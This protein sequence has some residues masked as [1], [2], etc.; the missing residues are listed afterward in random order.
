VSG[1]TGQTSAAVWTE[2][3]IGY[4]LVKGCAHLILWKALTDDPI[5]IKNRFSHM[6]MQLEVNG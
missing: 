5:A 1:E 2:T 3:S 4:S 6:K